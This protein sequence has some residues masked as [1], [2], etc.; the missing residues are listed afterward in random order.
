M[1]RVAAGVDLRLGATS[2]LAAVDRVM[3]SAFEPRYGEAWTYNQC[4]GIMALPGVWLTLAERD[5]VLVGFALSRVVM[6][7]AELLLLACEPRQ[8]GSGIG[9]ALLRSVMADAVRRGAAR[10]HLEVRAGNPAI[11]LYDREGFQPVGRRRDYYKGSN[12]KV[13]DAVSYNRA[14]P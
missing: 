1:N 13:F 12:G 5:G 2:D 8:R 7:E 10:L 11:G 3:R 14:I 4:M 6:D 9:G